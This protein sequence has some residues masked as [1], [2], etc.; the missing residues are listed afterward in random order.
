MLRLPVITAA[1]SMTAA[2]ERSNAPAI[3]AMVV[4]DATMS[5]T[6][7]ARPMLNMFW[8]L[9]KNSESTEK[10]MSSATHATSRATASSRRTRRAPSSGEP[11]SRRRGSRLGWTSGGCRDGSTA[12]WSS[13][14]CM[15]DQ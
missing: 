3:R 7:T 1:R 9:R 2:I 6:A 13:G 12:G 11:P 15:A 8:T 5:V 14:G 10:R 4:P